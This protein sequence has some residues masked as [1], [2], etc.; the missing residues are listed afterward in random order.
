MIIKDQIE[1]LINSYRENFRKETGLG[2]IIFPETNAE[3]VAL[4]KLKQSTLLLTGIIIDEKCRKVETIK[5]KQFYIRLAIEMEYSDKE[6]SSC[7]KMD[8]SSVTIYRRSLLTGDYYFE[9][10]YAK[11]KESIIKL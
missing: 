4:D 7:L 5:I 6:I 1:T 8:R 9:R 2:L 11:F 10:E 3:K